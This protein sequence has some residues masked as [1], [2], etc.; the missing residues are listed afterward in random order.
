[1]RNLPN[2]TYGGI[3]YDLAGYVRPE[4]PQCEPISVFESIAKGIKNEASV[5]GQVLSDAPGAIWDEV[6]NDWQHHRGKMLTKEGISLAVGVGTGIALSRSSFLVKGVLGL[7]AGYQGYHLLSSTGAVIGRAWHADSER[8]QHALAREA[9]VGLSKAGADL[10]ETTPA[11]MLGG[12][13]GMLA[14]GRFGATRTMAL[15]MRE[16]V[17]NPLES[18]CER[19]ASAVAQSPK[20]LGLAAAELVPGS[21]RERC[22]WVGPGTRQLPASLLSAD[23]KINILET[24]K[25]MADLHQP[26]AENVPVGASHGWFGRTATHSEQWA[27]VRLTDLKV[28]R[29]YAGKSLELKMPFPDREGRLMFHTHPPEGMSATY[30][31]AGARPSIADLKSTV[32]VGII[33]SGP[34]TTIYQ[35]AAREFAASELGRTPFQPTLRALFLDRERQLAAE[36]TTRWM[37]AAQAYQPS[38]IRP[39][40]YSQATKILSN[41]DRR[42]SSIAAIP[43]DTEVLTNLAN[44]HVFEFLKLGVYKHA[45]S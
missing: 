18:G 22:A 15:T 21:L 43:T 4:P 41:W 7:L 32:D 8:Y 31:V 2:D 44:P 24:S 36:L 10:L 30:P 39:L 1:M 38:I 19:M 20:A 13:V 35:G 5:L 33:Q 37:P 25:I 17:N 11:F 45:G 40:D 26:M 12:G 23:G 27:S 34:L 42:W 3:K 29:T 6:K 14:G 9:T 28:T 16:H